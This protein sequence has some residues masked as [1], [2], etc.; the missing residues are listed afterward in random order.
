MMSAGV[1]DFASALSAE[2]ACAA[3]AAACFAFAGWTNCISA[4]ANWNVEAMAGFARGIGTSSVDLAG[5]AAA[6]RPA[7]LD[8]STAR[9]AAALSSSSSLD[10]PLN[11]MANRFGVLLVEVSSPLPRFSMSARASSY[12]LSGLPSEGICTVRPSGNTRAS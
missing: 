11:N 1:C 3:T 7:E 8:F 5:R 6:I 12:P 2:N 10:L 4:E 9:G